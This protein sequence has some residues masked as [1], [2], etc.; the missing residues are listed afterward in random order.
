[1]GAHDLVSFIALDEPGARVP[2]RDKPV[3]IEHENRVIL[4]AFDQRPKPLLALAKRL[5]VAFPLCKV[6]GDLRETDEFV[7]FI[8]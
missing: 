5:V 6:A 2:S 4:Y 1:M 8:P 3:G 7:T